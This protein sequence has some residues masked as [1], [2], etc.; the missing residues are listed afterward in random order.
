LLYVLILYGDRDDVARAEVM[1]SETAAGAVEQAHRT[2][3]A[4]P[5][6]L[7][8]ELWHAGTKV[9]THFFRPR[10]RKQPLMP[11]DGQQG[12]HHLR[13]HPSAVQFS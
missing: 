10:A 2:A 13:L 11:P 3:L 6:Y 8:Y 4:A 7:G 12:S 1:S 5:G 9:A